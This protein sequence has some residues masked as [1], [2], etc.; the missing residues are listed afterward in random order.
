[1]AGI[2]GRHPAPLETPAPDPQT[3]NHSRDIPTDPEI[4]TNAAIYPGTIALA[5]AILN[6]GHSRTIKQTP[7]ADTLDRPG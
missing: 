5:A 1:M 6:P 7:S 3:T 4:Y 2:P